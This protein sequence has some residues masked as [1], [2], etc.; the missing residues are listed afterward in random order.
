MTSVSLAESFSMAMGKSFWPWRALMR[1]A[2]WGSRSVKVLET[3]TPSM[4][5][6]VDAIWDLG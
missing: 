2:R 6:G 3:I 1:A 5:A 4:L